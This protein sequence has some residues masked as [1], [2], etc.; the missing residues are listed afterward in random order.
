MYI[1]IKHDDA[2]SIST[3]IKSITCEKEE[4]FLFLENHIIMMNTNIIDRESGGGE[5]MPTPEVA[6]N[7]LI[8]NQYRQIMFKMMKEIFIMI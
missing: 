5:Q 4:T 2:C 6:S 7:A 1:C 3:S 8:H